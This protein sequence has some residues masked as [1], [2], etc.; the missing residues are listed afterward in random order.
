ME[1]NQEKQFNLTWALL[2]TG[3][4]FTLFAFMLSFVDGYDAP[5]FWWI[6]GIS[7]TLGIITG[8]I[9]LVIKRDTEKLL[10]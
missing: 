8:I 4:C 7:F 6:G 3:F 1:K 10:S 5:V 9:A 2:V